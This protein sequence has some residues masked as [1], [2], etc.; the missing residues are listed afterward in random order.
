M[1]FLLN[2]LTVV[3]DSTY[4]PVLKTGGG[5]LVRFVEMRGIFSTEN[6]TDCGARKPT[7]DTTIR[8][9]PLRHAVPT[10]HLRNLRVQSLTPLNLM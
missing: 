10:H 2:S 4:P 8:A 3:D 7:A 1:G 5:Q 6:T 9:T